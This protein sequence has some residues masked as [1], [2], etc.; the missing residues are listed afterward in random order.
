MH[1]LFLGPAK[2]VMKNIWLS[3]KHAVLD[4]KDNT[5]IHDCVANAIVPTSVGRIPRKNLSGFASFTA[6]QWK[7]WTIIY[8]VVALHDVI[9]DLDKK[10]WK[11]FV[12]M[13][14]L[15]CTSLI[16][17]TDIEIEALTLSFELG[18]TVQDLYGEDAVTPNMRLHSF[19]GVHF[20][21]WACL[22]V[23]AV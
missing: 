19:K 21:L 8:L 7:N 4:R 18:Q 17:I 10:C 3:E 13:C 22:W 9:P 6:D 11:M 2:Y 15:F 16:S 12:K 20:R 1:N 5:I 14:I 23:L